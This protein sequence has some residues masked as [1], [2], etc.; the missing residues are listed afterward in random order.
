VTTAKPGSQRRIPRGEQ[1][2]GLLALA[3]IGVAAWFGVDWLRADGP[4]P[5][6]ATPAATPAPSAAPTPTAAP[7]PDEARR[8]V[9]RSDAT[10]SRVFA[11]AEATASPTVK[12]ARTNAY[13]VEVETSVGLDPAAV[14]REVHSILDDPRGWAGYGRNNFQLVADPKKAA[15]RVL[16][17]SPATVDERCGEARTRGLWSCRTG[18]T[19][20]LNS[21]RWQFMVPNYNNL[22]AHRAWLVNH[23]VGAWLGQR[24]AFCTE[25][26]VA[27]PVMMQQDRDLDGCLPNAWPSTDG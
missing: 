6:A 15:L 5:A 16:V 21:D 14:A 18:D 20:V 1:A 24:L 19:V 9:W 27:A 3:F 13:T 10:A 22:E 23:H 2:I 12:A 11:L 4:A 25:K 8:S 26:G 7:I 17:A